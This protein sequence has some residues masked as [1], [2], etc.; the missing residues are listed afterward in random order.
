MDFDI[1]MKRYGFKI[2]MI[3]ITV[4]ALIVSL[5][6]LFFYLIA[7]KKEELAYAI[8]V[9]GFSLAFALVLRST[10]G[11]ITEYKKSHRKVHGES[12]YKIVQKKTRR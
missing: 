1:F 6:Y 9:I 10:K 12:L 5:H 2:L 7:I 11:I 3:F 8:L 4:I